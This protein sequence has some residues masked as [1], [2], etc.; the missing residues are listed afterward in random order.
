MYHRWMRGCAGGM[1]GVCD[2]ADEWVVVSLL[3]F[4]ERLSFVQ[5][6]IGRGVVGDVV[7]KVDD[8]L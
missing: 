1:G 2:S 4:Y 5:R 6:V 7:V 8:E 3:S